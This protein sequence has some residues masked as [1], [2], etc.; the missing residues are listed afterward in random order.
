MSITSEVAI[1]NVI[2]LFAEIDAYSRWHIGKSVNSKFVYGE[3]GFGSAEE[4][5][6]RKEYHRH[7]DNDPRDLPIPGRKSVKIYNHFAHGEKECVYCMEVTATEKPLHSYEID[8][9]HIDI[10][11]ENLF[12]ICPDLTFAILLVVFNTGTWQD[13]RGIL[14]E[15]NLF[16]GDVEGYRNDL[17]S[18]DVLRR[19]MKNETISDLDLKDLRKKLYGFAYAIDNQ[20]TNV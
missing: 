7:N 10:S 4:L 9:I 20:I 17:V 1:E 18:L 3:N 6:K 12:I 15:Q 11:P 8:S 16:E 2:L 14:Q 13:W 5:Q 19:K